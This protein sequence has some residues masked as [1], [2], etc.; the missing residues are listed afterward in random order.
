RVTNAALAR[1]VGVE[2]N[3]VACWMKKQ[4]F[5]EAMVLHSHIVLAEWMPALTTKALEMAAKGDRA[6]LRF[7]LEKGFDAIRERDKFTTHHNKQVVL[8]WGTCANGSGPPVN[9]LTVNSQPIELSP[10]LVEP[11]IEPE[12]EEESLEQ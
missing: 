8:Q 6:M 5:R 4:S 7:M 9:Q 2:R 12:P 10:V 3:T 1:R 11:D